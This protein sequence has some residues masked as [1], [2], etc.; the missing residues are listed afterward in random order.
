MSAKVFGLALTFD[1]TSW[2]TM[3]ESIGAAARFSG[4]FYVGFGAGVIYLVWAFRRR[5]VPLTTGLDYLAPALAL[6]H[7]I[8]RIGCLMAGCCW[9][10]AC[11][12]PWAIT[13]TSAE[14]A[15]ITGVP[16]D[17]ALH[18][19]QI[20]ESLGEFLIFGVILAWHLRRPGFAGSTILLYVMF[21]GVLR[22]GLETLRADPRGTVLDGALSTSQ[23]LAIFSLVLVGIAWYVLRKRSKETSA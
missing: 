9:G 6:A 11:D 4:H 2:E 20:Y 3:K 14:A 12:L 22:F 16:L 5:G 8:G 13:F 23:G 15:D 19:T 10:K 18:P 1:A 21:Y 17:V 7:A